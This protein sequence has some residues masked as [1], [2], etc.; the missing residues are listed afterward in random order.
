[1]H[2]ALR[3]AALSAFVS[4]CVAPD[5]APTKAWTPLLDPASLGSW[6][7]T[8]FGGEGAVDLQPQRAT[9][10]FGS[11]LTGVTWTGPFPTDRYEIAGTA[12]RVEGNDFFY[13]LTFP[14]REAHLTLVVGGWGGTLVGISSLDGADASDNETGTHLALRNGTAYHIVVRVDWPHLQV[15]IDDASVVDLDLTDRELSLRPEVQPSVPLGI[16]SFATRAEIRNLA[17]RPL[18]P[19]PSPS[20]PTVR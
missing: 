13:G 20:P 2:F 14:V 18:S 10:D 8:S 6:T 19:A 11:P 15:W 1:M 9:L 16:A 4:G 17:W 5:P 7:P 12:T 3:I